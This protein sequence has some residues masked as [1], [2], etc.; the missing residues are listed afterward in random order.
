MSIIRQ[1]EVGSRG[2]GSGGV[3]ICRATQLGLLRLLSN[4]AIL[5]NSALTGANA[6]ALVAGLLE[7]DRMTFLPEPTGISEIM[8]PLL[9]YPVP[10]TKLIMDAYLAAFAIASERQLVTFDKGFKQ[11]RGLD[12]A[13]L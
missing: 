5:G 1:P 8:P 7:D 9:T 6:W 2:Q 13:L 10:T 11:Y 12:V 4:R 3:G